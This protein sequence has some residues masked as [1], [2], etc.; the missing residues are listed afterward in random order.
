MKPSKYFIVTLLVLS[1]LP[2]IGLFSPGL[3]LTHDGPDHVARIANF[4]RSLSEGNILPRWAENL[5]WGYGH[6]ILMFLYP[7][8]SYFASLFHFIGFTF[9][10]S[11]KMVFGVSF[12]ISII[13]MYL[14]A[15]KRWGNAIGLL[16]ALLY[17]FAPYRFVDM[18]VRGAIGEHVAF[19]FP[20]LILYFIDELSLTWKDNYTG[21]KEALLG[22]R[23]G[24]FLSL[25]VAGLVM[26]HNAISLM[27][28]PIIGLYVLYILFFETKNRSLFIASS[29]LFII[30]GFFLSA[31]YWIPALFEGKYTLR[32]IVTKGDAITRFVPILN[33]FYSPWNYG[34]G[35][36][37]T[38]SV[39]IV[40]WLGIALS[41]FVLIHERTRKIRV[42]M[43]GTLLLFIF[44]LFLQTK[45]S[46]VIWNAITIIQKFQ[47][48]WRF[49]TVSVFLS[50]I[51][52]GWAIGT[53]IE[54]FAKDKVIPITVIVC[55]IIVVPVYFMWFPKGV[56]HHP[57]GYYTGVYPGT[58]DTGESSPIWSV[59][60]MEHTFNVPLE[61]IDGDI[62]VMRGR[63]TSTV[64]E[65]AIQ[66]RD[67]GRLVENTL[68][69]PGWKIYIDG[70]QT[71]IQFQEPMYR[72]L[73]TFSVPEGNHSILVHFG[74]TKLRKISNVISL[75]SI[76]V[77]ILVITGQHMYKLMKI[78]N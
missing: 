2:L 52:S 22:I 67:K 43:F 6:P 5:N 68:Y 57:E 53:F 21:V 28:L 13:T 65:Y 62:T 42:F 48:P 20:P 72:G 11:T 9:V 51:L 35:N 39:G 47:F 54:R 30:T 70:V 50:S 75:V 63:R 17:G 73:M 58:T 45:E 46:I 3:P 23:P 61:V 26:A 59:R 1:A 37:F 8:P 7:L 27:F 77:I 40:E 31:F 32:D 24:I 76:I 12:M 71:E 55:L 18:Y 56:I 44:S 25:S 41:V 33:F 78:H 14:W 74:D 36:E 38:K 64:H 4:Y 60:F 29:L 34:S 69:F 49:L 10:D 16:I 15:A 19:I 66:A